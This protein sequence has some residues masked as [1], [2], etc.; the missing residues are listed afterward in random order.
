MVGW[1]ISSI[2]R[3]KISRVEVEGDMTLSIS[4]TTIQVDLLLLQND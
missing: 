3:V 4:E 2:A 1:T